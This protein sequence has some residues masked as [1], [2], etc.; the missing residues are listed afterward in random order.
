[1][2][3]ALVEHLRS[4]L[5]IDSA[6]LYSTGMS[7]G[8][9]M[10]SVLACARA[11]KFAAFAAVSVIFYRNPCGGDHAMAFMGI[12]GT[13][14]PVVAVHRGGG[15]W[16]GGAGVPGERTWPGCRDGSEIVFYIIDGG[17]HTWP[18]AL[19]VA[20]LGKTTNQLD[21]SETIWAFF[22]AHPLR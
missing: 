7:Y 14:D 15:R 22:Q 12:M 9:A 20:R 6:R 3:D 10:T 11:N 13:A 5:C 1:M 18:G 17:G 19:P 4:E 8:G 2:V 21:A 16:R